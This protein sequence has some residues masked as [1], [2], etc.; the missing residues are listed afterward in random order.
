MLW[1]YHGE[2]LLSG[3][4][5]LPG[6]AFAVIG[7]TANASS[8][9][10]PGTRPDMA[11]LVGGLSGFLRQLRNHQL[12]ELLGDLVLGSELEDL[13]QLLDRL[14]RVAEEAILIAEQETHG[15]VVWLLL[16]ALLE[17]AQAID[18]R[19]CVAV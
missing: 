4:A 9:P 19:L 5:V 11:V 10:T 18:E 17:V 8:R 6:W 16:A 2:V 15:G 14:L 1:I 13:V 3:G 7:R 12:A